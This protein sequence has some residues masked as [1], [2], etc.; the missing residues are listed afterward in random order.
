MD[1]LGGPKVTAR[2]FRMEEGGRRGLGVGDLKM[3]Y[4]SFED[5]RRGP[6]LRNQEA[7]RS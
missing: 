5:G 1:Y 2:A 6:E 7:S 4:S 3:L